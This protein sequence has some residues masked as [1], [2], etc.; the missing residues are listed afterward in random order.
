VHLH[1]PLRAAQRGGHLR[2]RQVPNGHQRHH[3]GL[4]AWQPPYRPPEVTILGRQGRIRPLPGAA[5]LGTTLPTLRKAFTRH[6]LGMPSPD[7]AA[8]SARKAAAAR[9]HQPPA[10]REL[11]GAFIVL[12]RPLVAPLASRARSGELSARVRRAEQEAT[13][14]YRVTTR[15]TAENHWP[16]RT[17]RAWTVRQRAQHAQQRAQDRTSERQ[18]ERPP[19]RPRRGRDEDQEGDRAGGPARRWAARRRERG[20]AER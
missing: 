8:V 15:L 7:P 10:T 1:R 12:N 19:V 14:G 13:L 16:S 9:D 4:A 17:A 6:Q 20:D 5:E 18:P 2:G 11:D 3:L